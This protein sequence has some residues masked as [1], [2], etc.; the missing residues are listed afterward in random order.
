MS[1]Q[2]GADFAG[3]VER[4][5]AHVAQQRNCR[6]LDWGLLDGPV[7]ILLGV[8]HQGRMGGDADCQGDDLA[9]FGLLRQLDGAFQGRF[10]PRDHHLPGAVIVGYLDDFARRAGFGAYL[11]QGGDIQPQ[12]GS[13]AAGGDVASL[14]HQF[15]APPHQ[16]E[17]LDEGQGASRH[18]GAQFAH[19]VPGNKGGVEI[20]VQLLKDEQGGGRMHQQSGLRIDRIVER[21][22]RPF[23]R[24]AGEGKTQRFIGLFEDR[25][26]RGIGPGQVAPHAEA[27]GTLP[28]EDE[29]SLRGVQ[30]HF[31]PLNASGP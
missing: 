17:G 16:L 22:F 14:F 13:H 21:F 8:G 3:L 5:G 10:G 30:H 7:E 1:A 19:R 27:L 25:P 6:I 20:G 2:V 11:I 18:Q 28:R 9:R 23:P 31:S 12:D 15:A 4:Q 26:R 24:Q 29:C